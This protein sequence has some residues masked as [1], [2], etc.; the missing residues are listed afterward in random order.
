M[1]GYQWLK[2]MVDNG[3]FAANCSGYNE[4]T[5]SNAFT[6]QK[7]LM[8]ATTSLDLLELSNKRAV[9]GGRL[10]VPRRSRGY[11]PLTARARRRQVLVSG[12]YTVP[13]S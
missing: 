13:S 5:A 3:V 4:S 8:I 12:V 9:R 2:D 7:S 10:P 1:K 6:L 11:N